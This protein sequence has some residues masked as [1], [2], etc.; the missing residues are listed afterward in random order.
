MFDFPG[1]RKG[2]EIIFFIRKQWTAYV[3]VI[4]RLLFNL[5][6]LFATSYFLVD[7]FPHNSITYFLLVEAMLFY[8][9]GV[10]WFTFNGWLDEELDTFVITNERIIDTTQSA[11]VSIEI[12][13]ADLDQVQDV[14]GKVAGFMGGLFHF[15]NLEVQTAGAKILFQMDHIE[16]PERYID[17]I[18]ERKNAY[19]AKKTGI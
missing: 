18:V 1:L 5:I 12:A 10:W 2:E 7:K 8:V 17:E 14:R 11:F 15:G 4:S 6:I 19:L 16:N 9:L 3:G 13:S